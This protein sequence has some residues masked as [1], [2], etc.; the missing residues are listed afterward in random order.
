MP[1]DLYTDDYHVRCRER[2]RA[3][4]N[5]TLHSFRYHM[6]KEKLT[7]EQIESRFGN[8]WNDV[9]LMQKAC[10]TMKNDNAMKRRRR[11][12]VVLL[13]REME[14]LECL[15]NSLK[16][17]VAKEEDKSDDE[18]TTG[19]GVPVMGDS[20]RCSRCGAWKDYMCEDTYMC[21]NC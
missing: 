11:R 5:S 18:P 19:M 12:T 7:D 16:E 9:A 3:N 20:T 14:R 2:E 15:E 10:D 17:P 4:Y 13:Q 8:V 21:M 6:K 1:R